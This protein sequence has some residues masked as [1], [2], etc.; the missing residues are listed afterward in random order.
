MAAVRRKRKGRLDA[1]RLLPEMIRRLLSVSDDDLL[2]RR[3]CALA[4][5]ALG[6][7][8]V[9]LLLMDRA[10][11]E[12][13]EHEVVG[14]RLRP[15][16][17]RLRVNEEGVA[18]WVASHREPQIVPDVQKDKRYVKVGEKVR[19]EAAVPILSGD[20]LIGVL[21]FESRQ[22]GFFQRR[23]LP[24]LEFLASQLA[25]ALRMAELTDRV[26]QW[27]ERMGAL[28]NISRLGGGVVPLE[29]MLRRV[30]E[31]VRLTCG[32]HYAAVFQGDYE[33]EELVLLAHS[34]AFPLNIAVGARQKFRTGLVG[35]AFELG[36][37]VNVHD[38]RRDA[39]YVA[40][41]PGVVS[42]MCVPIRVGDN[43][44]GILDTQA[45]VPGEFSVDEVTFLETVARFLAPALQSPAPIR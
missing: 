35:K 29:T 25:I 12:L 17:M 43:S 38:V 45:Q 30:V 26:R 1:M 5:D 19:S 20:R 10:G 7:D 41:V 4:N 34:S 27:Q 14:K 9:S 24:A 15:T 32:G 22:L 39:M 3:V 40:R 18:G 36:E 8:E 13:V 11:R 28:Q 16:R 37:T 2:L 44:V 6:A 33:R 23:D 21:N 42:E 31:A